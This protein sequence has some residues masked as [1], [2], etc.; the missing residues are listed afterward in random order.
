MRQGGR[1]AIQ[2]FDAQEKLFYRLEEYYPVGASPSGLSIRRPDFSINREKH[3]GR[4]EYVLIPNWPDHGIAEFF[5]DHLPTNL[6]TAG[7]VQFTWSPIHVPEENNYFHSEVH[8][9]KNG[10][11]ARK[12]SQL[13]DLI[14][15]EFK[16]RLSE[17][18]RVIKSYTA[19]DL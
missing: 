15:R 7:A 10:T 12:S 11:R 5:V 3:G 16:Q 19:D 18:M 4:A 8:T 14:W 6:R 17:K 1:P 2:D 9:F 13:N